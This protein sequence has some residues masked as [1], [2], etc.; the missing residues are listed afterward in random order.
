M[1]YVG[2]DIAKGSH[3]AAII[4]EDGKL[5]CSP[6]SFPNTENG[7]EKIL[8]AF[9]KHDIAKDDVIIAMESTGI[10]WL[11]VYS[12]FIDY[13]FDVKVINP[14]QTNSFRNLNIRKC[15]TDII[16][17]V[18]IAQL[19]RFGK[20]S[21]CALPDEKIIALKN[22]SRYRFFLV[23]NCAQLKSKVIH[24]LDQVFPEYEKLFSNV[25]GTTSKELLLKFTIPEEFLE[26]STVKLTNLIDKLSYHRLGRTKA[27][28]IKR[29]AQG[30]FGVSFATKS[31]AFQIKQIIEQLNFIEQHLDEL[32]KEITDILAQTD[33]A[34][35]TSI[36]GIGSVLAAAIVG[37]VG[38]I[39]KFD[40][41]S[42][43]LAY[44]GLDTSIMQ[45]GQ[46]LGTQGKISKRGSPL[47]RRAFYL[48]ALVA[49]FKDPAL[50]QF[51]ARKMSQGKH[52]KQALIAV[53]H[54]LVNI[55][56]AIWRSGK[57]YIPHSK[58]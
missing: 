52:H 55:T 1:Y 27:E 49:A 35:L 47:L 17:S 41:P 8:A 5:V 20:Y 48:A 57:P 19:V 33:A 42:K 11:S 37:E 2:I 51:Y 43:L 6:F 25:S 9:T 45:S 38:D 28:E 14:I 32:E 34:V 3:E 36:T 4:S 50:S 24:L 12:F 54:K 21:S 29:A 18:N 26:I 16:D 15:K 13:G 10:Y 40:S 23:D 39:Q 30:S 58:N 56:W 7:C 53:A 44:A 31:F 46:F 22:L